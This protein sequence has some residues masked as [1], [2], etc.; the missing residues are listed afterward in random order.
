MA[1]DVFKRKQVPGDWT[2]GDDVGFTF[3]WH[4]AKSRLEDVRTAVDILNQDVSDWYKTSNRKKGPE[5]ERFIKGWEIWKN[6]FFKWY[7]DATSRWSKLTPELPWSVASKAEAKTNE[8][9]EWRRQF[10]KVAGFEATG[11]GPLVR[12]GPPD[13]KNEGTSMWAWV[14]AALGGAAI[15]GF[16]QHKLGG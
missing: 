16:V 7:D 8:L 5:Q 12:E 15:F 10:E 9:N 13:K 11:P 3:F 14:A 6:E 4:T 2:M 1:Y